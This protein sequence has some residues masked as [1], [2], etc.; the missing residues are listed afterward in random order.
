MSSS[1]RQTIVL[2]V[3]DHLVWFILA[4]SVIL[5][6]LTIDQFFQVG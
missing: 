1:P 2:W 6:S 5:F 4:T 3:L